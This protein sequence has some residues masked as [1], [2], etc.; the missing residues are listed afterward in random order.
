M[1]EIDPELG[2]PAPYT[3]NDGLGTLPSFAYYGP[4]EEFLI[5]AYK[6][7]I[8]AEPGAGTHA[9]SLLR[10]FQIRSIKE[11]FWRA[12]NVFK[13]STIATMRT[14]APF[15]PSDSGFGDAPGPDSVT[16]GAV[17]TGT[18]TDESDPLLD[19][20]LFKK[21]VRVA[22]IGLPP[23]DRGFLS[24]DDGF[25]HKIQQRYIRYEIN[26]SSGGS[27]SRVPYAHASN[28]NLDFGFDNDGDG[29]PFLDYYD[30]AGGYRS[31]PWITMSDRLDMYARQSRFRYSALDSAIAGPAGIAVRA[32][33]I[34]GG[35][36]ERLCRARGG[37]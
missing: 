5:G 21:T 28:Y 30:S 15:Y 23:H 8:D 19:G 37:G 35:L 34:T 24:T 18:G 10:D 29:I 26:P 9:N 12:Q 27:D 32:F 31:A 4:S 22:T 14:L 17:G 36:R 25:I 6:T 16:V 13:Y 33:A 3:Y 2:T 1:S 20:H 11:D 7:A